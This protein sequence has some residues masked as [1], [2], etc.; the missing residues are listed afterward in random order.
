MPQLLDLAA[1]RDTGHKYILEEVDADRVK[2]E[3]FDSPRLI[4]YLELGEGLDIFLHI[5]AK[6][7]L[8]QHVLEFRFL[9]VI[10]EVLYSLKYHFH[11][12]HRSR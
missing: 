3:P 4:S 10:S 2:Y 11:P 9:L 7:R 12:F 8:A 5:F 1:R 6:N